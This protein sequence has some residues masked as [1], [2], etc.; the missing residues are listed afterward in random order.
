VQQIIPLPEAESYQIK[1]RDK[2]VVERAARTQNRDM[3]RYDVTIAD[4]QITDL[5]KRRAIYQVIRGLCDAGVDP[6]AIRRAVPW[7]TTILV[8][9]AGLLDSDAYE[10]ALAAQLISQGRKPLTQRF[11][12]DNNELIQANGKTYAATKTWGPRTTLAIDELLKT[13]P[14]HRISY[15]EAE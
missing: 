3:T 1:I 5:P 10:K 8:P 11:F 4:K 13:F 15:R 7:K 9:I 14:G 6:D 2:K 12:I